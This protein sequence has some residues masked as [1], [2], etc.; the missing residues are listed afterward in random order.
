MVDGRTLHTHAH[1]RLQESIKSQMRAS[2]ETPYQKVEAVTAAFAVYLQNTAFPLHY[3]QVRLP[4]CPIRRVDHERGNQA[5]VKSNFTWSEEQRRWTRK[6]GGILVAESEILHV[7]QYFI[8]GTTQDSAIDLYDTIH[9]QVEGVYYGD[10]EK[11]WELWQ[12]SGLSRVEFSQAVQWV[13]QK[14]IKL[15]GEAAYLII[16]C[17]MDSN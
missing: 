15:Q 16:Q 4:D 9:K 10:V 2:K 1:S 17:V 7:I 5:Q 13:G 3:I 14:P 11:A 12:D 6:D 8:R